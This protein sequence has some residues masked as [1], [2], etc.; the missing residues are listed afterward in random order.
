MTNFKKGDF[1]FGISDN[2]IYICFFETGKNNYS[3]VVEFKIPDSLT[4]NLNFKIIQNLLKKNIRELEKK[5]GFFLNDGN[6]SI[7]SESYQR[8]LFSVKN[9]F[10]EQ[11]LDKK[12]IIN[13]IQ[14]AIQQFEKNEKNLFITHII[15]NKYVIDD[16]VYKYL[17]NE[18]RF[19][20]I[21]LEIEF[22]CVEKQLIEKVKKLFNECKININK[23]VSYDYAKKF[24]ISDRD[25]TMCISA[26][27][28]LNGEN[29][30]EVY[31]IEAMPEKKGIFNKVFGLFD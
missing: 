18:I 3:D 25:D 14:S 30:S 27:K 28:V 20:K 8:I 29:Q 26:K 6:I 21:I 12:I 7:K 11:M 1:Y 9:I 23:I 10:D 17:P 15:I 22:I 16:K 24:L 4:N 2:K 19:K 31:F 13:L 5:L